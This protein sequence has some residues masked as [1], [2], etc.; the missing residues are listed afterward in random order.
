MQSMQ[1]K[2]ALSAGNAIDYIAHPL[3]HNPPPGYLGLSLCNRGDRYFRLNDAHAHS[4]L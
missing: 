2:F 3:Y 4:A 1:N